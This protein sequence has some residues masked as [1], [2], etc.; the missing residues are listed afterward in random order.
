MYVFLLF[1]HSKTTYLTVYLL[2]T[3]KLIYF[4]TAQFIRAIS[5]LC[6][7]TLIIVSYYECF[8][9][10]LFLV[11]VHTNPSCLNICSTSLSLNLIHFHKLGFRSLPKPY[12]HLHGFVWWDD[13]VASTMS[14]VADGCDLRSQKAPLL[15]RLPTRHY[16]IV[17]SRRSV[18]AVQRSLRRELNTRPRAH[19]TRVLALLDHQKCLRISRLSIHLNLKNFL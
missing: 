13:S 14:S 6:V 19:T 15:S 12:S 11:T 5:F 16:S 10:T 18:H 8:S 1:H 4:H 7:S 17:S 3:V 2:L 9:F